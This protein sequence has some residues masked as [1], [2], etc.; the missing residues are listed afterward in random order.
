M[1]SIPSPLHRIIA[2]QRRVKSSQQIVRPAKVPARDP[3]EDDV[4]HKLVSANSSRSPRPQTSG[5]LVTISFCSRSFY[6]CRFRVQGKEI[7]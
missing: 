5:H 1:S 6:N 3:N 2:T 7:T 4:Y